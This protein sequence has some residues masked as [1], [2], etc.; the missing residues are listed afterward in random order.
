MKTYILVALE[1]ELGGYEFDE[2]T[3][4]V[5]TGV[6]KINAAMT[7]V[8]ACAANDC[9]EII[10]FGTAGV[11]NRDLMGKLNRIGT[12]YQRDMDA[13]PLASL[14]ITP[15][16]DG[17]FNGPITVHKSPV[18]L[19]TGDN[20]VTA[21]PELQTDMVDM[22]AYAIAKIAKRFGKPVH[23]LKYGS[24]CVTDDNSESDWQENVAKGA[25]LF[26]EWYDNR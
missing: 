18:T 9:A 2:N 26:K 19:S 15:F 14:G 13:R 11:T 5:F 10:N 25:E 23:I 7:A 22:E 17:E 16:E 1:Q 3:K 21:I 20:F 6:G 8:I 12:V 4:V 24:D